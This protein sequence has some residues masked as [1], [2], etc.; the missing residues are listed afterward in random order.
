M[1][2]GARV[3]LHHRRADRRG[4]VD[5]L[6]A[7]LDEQRHANAGAVQFVDEGHEMIMAADDV[8]PAFGGALGALLRHE[9]DGVRL[10]LQ[11][12][13]EHLLGRRHLEIQRLGDRRLQPRHV[14]VAN[15]AAILAQMRGDAVGAGLDGEQR[16]AHGIRREARRARCGSVATWSTFT[17]RR[18]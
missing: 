4:G 6:G 15:M 7:R 11:R 12:D 13:V 9:A 14:V 18:M 2:P 3:Q 17:P 1:A 16:R 8:E 5:R 10:R